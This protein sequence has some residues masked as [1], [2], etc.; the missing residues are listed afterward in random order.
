MD[1]GK[2]RPNRVSR[3]WIIE[4]VLVL[5]GLSSLFYFLF[6]TTFQAYFSV[7]EEH[8]IVSASQAT[9]REWVHTAI[10]DTQRFGRFRPLY[11]LF[12]FTKIVL[13]GLNPYILHII[14]TGLGVLTCF[15]LY[16][17]MRQVGTDILSAL[18]FI[19]LFAMTGYQN[20][21]WYQ[22]FTPQE[23][24]GMVFISISVWAIVKAASQG[25]PG[26]WDTLALVTMAS[27]GLTKESFVLLIPALLLLRWTLHCWFSQETW[28]PA[29]RRLRLPL[30][31][32]SLTFIAEMLIIAVILLSMPKSYSANAAGLS[33]N[34][35]DLRVWYQLL[36]S[37][38]MATTVQYLLAS[39]LILVI[40]C[41]WPGQRSTRPYLLAGS[42][43]GV[44]WLMPQLVLYHKGLVERYLFPVIVAPAAVVGLSLA[45]LWQ[46]RTWLTRLVWLTGVLWLLPTLSAGLTTTT[47]AANRYTAETLTIHEM[48][49][50]LAQNVP[51]S[52]AIIT[53]ADPGTGYGFEA[54]YALP[55][56]LEVAGSESPVYLWPVISQDKRS[57]IHIAVAHQ[58]AAKFAYPETLTSDHIEGVI[59][60]TTPNDFITLPT[61]FINSQWQ[62]ITFTKS[63]YAFSLQEL[64]YIKAGEVS[65]RV[66][67]R[68]ES[69]LE[70]PTDHPLII[71]APSLKGKVGINP[72]L[73]VPGW[74]VGQIASASVLWLGHGET[75]GLAGTLWSTEKR[76]VQAVFEVE[77]GPAR[78]DSLRTVEL[79]VKNRAGIQTVRQQFDE[80]TRLNFTGELQP[81]RNDFQFTILDEATILKQ[82][83]GDTRPL[84]VLL[85]QINI[86]PLIHN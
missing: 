33:L 5:I 67:M 47:Q 68:G 74:G 31:V 48:V 29:L 44:A 78:I 7:I 4:C 81:G 20:V 76:A 77:P 61:W 54:I 26:W 83:N 56:Y 34:S 15:F 41:Y 39:A 19:L 45:V 49:T 71:V 13:F 51:A 10:D 73:K 60:V 36:T 16:I 62:E 84:L 50:H 70:F 38:G 42:L 37:P 32:G 66:L 3:V 63:Y 21:I 64:N 1:N 82:P 23:T 58:T 43:I 24:L 27:A 40:Y 2:D 80:A 72:L 46:R 11:F 69:P 75:E 59:M 28:L 14:T 53:V 79:T 30:V 57:S 8:R 85:R 9:I 12:H 65:H 55:L 17:A 18:F 25:K 35:F 22:I 52:K 86:E 6:G